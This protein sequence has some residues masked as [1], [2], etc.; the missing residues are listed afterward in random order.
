VGF[1]CAALTSVG[2]D[3]GP[4]ELEGGVVSSADRWRVLAKLR[5]LGGATGSWRPNKSHNIN[6]VCTGQPYG[7]CGASLGVLDGPAELGQVPRG[8]VTGNPKFTEDMRET[9]QQLI[10]AL[11]M[12]LELK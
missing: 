7:D 12:A 5:P 3:E 1:V 2:M 4:A 11:A 9:R 8:S 10:I 6:D